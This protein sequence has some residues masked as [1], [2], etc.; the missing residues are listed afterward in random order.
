MVSWQASSRRVPRRRT[1]TPHMAPPGPR[2]DTQTATP[3]IRPPPCRLN[4][5]PSRLSRRL[6]RK[7]PRLRLLRRSR[8]A[9]RRHRAA[10]TPRRSSRIRVRAPFQFPATASPPSARRWKR[11]WHSLRDRRQARRPR[12]QLRRR[13]SRRPAVT[14]SFLGGCSLRVGPDPPSG[15][16]IPQPTNPP[17]HHLRRLAPA[18]PCSTNRCNSQRAAGRGFRF[19]PLP[20]SAYRFSSERLSC[21][22]SCFRLLWIDAIQR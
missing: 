20:A 17:W 2:P 16:Q 9:T 12:L 6:R 21:C 15:A 3:T 13:L 10:F 8:P 5:R 22:S 7:G 11:L 4:R 1:P 18:R 19:R 14:R